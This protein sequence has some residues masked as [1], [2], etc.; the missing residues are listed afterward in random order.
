MGAMSVTVVLKYKNMYK[1]QSI[2]KDLSIL[3]IL[4]K[5]INVLSF[6]FFTSITLVS[7]GEVDV[8]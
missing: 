7:N 4:W 1:D 6:F 8:Y 2:D 5:D 3:T